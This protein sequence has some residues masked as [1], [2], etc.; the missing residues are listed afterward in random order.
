[1]GI[2]MKNT[3]SNCKYNEKAVNIIDGRSFTNGLYMKS[4]LVWTLLAA[5]F[6]G[7][8]WA[9]DVSNR[10]PLEVVERMQ[11][12]GIWQ[13]EFDENGHALNSELNNF[14]DGLQTTNEEIA[15]SDVVDNIFGQKTQLNNYKFNELYNVKVLIL[16][17]IR[18]NRNTNFKESKVKLVN[19]LWK[20]RYLNTVLSLV[21]LSKVSNLSQIAVRFE[22]LVQQDKIEILDLSENLRKRLSKKKSP[23]AKELLKKTNSQYAITGVFIPNQNLFAVDFAKE[24]IEQTIVTFVHEMIHAADPELNVAKKEFKD[25]YPKAVTYLR[26]WS[27]EE[28]VSNIVNI[29]FV[30]SLFFESEIKEFNDYNTSLKNEKLKEL[31]SDLDVNT[32]NPDELKTVRKWIQA[33]LRLSVLNEYHAYGKSLQFLSE[34]VS[35]FGL[36]KG[37]IR[38][39]KALVNEFLAGDDVFISKLAYDANPFG[40]I[41]L[42]SLRYRREEAKYNYITK[43]IKYLEYIYLDEI[44]KSVDVKEN[45]YSQHLEPIKNMTAPSSS[46]SMQ[47]WAESNGFDFPSNPYQLITA[48]LTTASTLKIKRNLKHISKVLQ[49]NVGQLQTSKAGVLD[50]SDTSAG[51]LKLLGIQWKKSRFQ[52]IDATAD[53]RAHVELDMVPEEIKKH[54]ELINWTKDVHIKDQGRTF[55]EGELVSQ[56]LV[57]LRLLK[58][59]LWLEA[60][61]QGWR[62]TIVGA[63]VFLEK[64][65]SEVNYDT[66][67]L[68][69]DRVFEL[70]ETLISVL[71]AS[72]LDY[73]TVYELQVLLEELAQVYHVADSK[74]WSELASKSFK[75]FDAVRRALERVGISGS[76]SL[77]EVK[78]SMVNDQNFFNDQ[79]KPYVQY[80]KGKDL[81]ILKASGKYGSTSKFELKNGDQFYLML[82]CYNDNLFAV[83]QPFDFT[84]YMTHSFTSDERLT[85]KIFKGSRKVILNPVKIKV[86][87]KRS[88]FLGI[89]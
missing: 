9:K 85:A 63:R 81:D 14:L 56:N 70:E 68:T 65:R 89:F 49:K 40:S 77:N 17:S 53:S 19:E 31:A 39:H 58:I 7:N 74:N 2:E 13:D 37:K 80:C 43:L 88:R 51:E 83:R 32:L 30:Q 10:L 50:L 44:Q 29:N 62:D 28:D 72:N 22:N 48:R 82:T 21:K 64:L 79:L 86:K 42:Y 24:S 76:K 36:V 47:S 35:R 69:E 27:G 57:K 25:L 5:T 23:H 66:R 1:M 75:Q 54:F 6:V 73:D 71:E 78:E 41:K 12:R 8:A 52:H 18:D 59:S 84:G 38:K 3:L 61:F 16:R 4:I 26:K 20:K 60:N 33:G 45:L 46:I 34:L 67:D 11:D 15:S 55:I 87:K